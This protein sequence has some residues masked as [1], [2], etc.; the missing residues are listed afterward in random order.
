VLLDV[1]STFVGGLPPDAVSGQIS[2]DVL[3]E[4]HRAAD[5]EVQAR[6]GEIL[7]GKRRSI[8]RLDR[9]KKVWK[10]SAADIRGWF[11]MPG[12]YAK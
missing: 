3:R 7:K 1:S 8:E 4:R 12:L 5:H 10:F 6:H 9:S 11:S 2:L